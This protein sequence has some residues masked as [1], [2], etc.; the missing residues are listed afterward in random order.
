M[1][2]RAIRVILV[3]LFA[4][5]ALAFAIA[6]ALAYADE[7]T[8]VYQTLD[9]LSGK[10]I[11]YVNGS[12]YNQAVQGRIDGTTEEFY[13]SL[14]ECVAAVEAGK[15]DAAVQL[16]YCCQ[17]AVNRRPGT[18]TLLPDPVVSVSE[19]FFFPRGSALTSQFNDI[20]KRFSEDGTLK[21]LEEKWV[22]ADESGKTLPEQDWDA[23]NGTL[24][25]ATSGVIEPFSYVGQGGQP[26]GYD[27]ELALLIARELGYHLEVTTI[28]MDSIFAAVDTGK[29]DFGGTL[30]NTPERAAVCDFSEP[31]MPTTISV[32]V[33]SEES[34]ESAGLF[35]GI[36]TSFQRT[37][38]EEDRWMLVLSGLGVTILISVFSGVLGLL[39]GYATVLA[40]RSGVRWVGKLVDGYQALM[41]RI[42]IVVVLMLFYYVVFGSVDVAGELV[43]VIAFT[44]AFGA[45]AGATMWTAVKGIDVIQEETGLALGYTR[46]EV[47]SK[48]VFPQARQQFTPQLMGQFVNLV[49]DT[50][51]VG[52]I[53][54]TDLTRASDLIRARTMDAFFPLITTAIIYFLFCMLLAYVLR[55]IAARFDVTKRPREI[56]GVDEK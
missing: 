43:A 55:K 12:V 5:V 20:I 22:A 28:P 53:S 40:R 56:Q 45:T 3:S 30:T 44:L 24:K 4:V 37:F 31:V 50:A 35:G 49:K 34:A 2:G 17:L 51:I 33:K 1:A 13:P 15:A 8:P 6:P 38:I 32:I 26:K 39:L 18:V 7:A 23:P 10:R 11:A 52:Y 54:V 41:G 16:S 21:E 42:P 27:V 29:A 19:G 47:F 9:E 14:A 36:A 25:F 48:I 46:W